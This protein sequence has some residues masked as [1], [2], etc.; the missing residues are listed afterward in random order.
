MFNKDD[1]I[2]IA[3][4]LDVFLDYFA[5]MGF[6]VKCERDNGVIMLDSRATV[7]DKEKLQSIDIVFQRKKRLYCVVCGLYMYLESKRGHCLL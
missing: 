4:K 2:F 5:Y 1:A 7:G 3:N 6:E